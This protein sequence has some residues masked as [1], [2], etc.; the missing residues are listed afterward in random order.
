ML[1]EPGLSTEYIHHRELQQLT[2]EPA[3]KSS[4]FAFRFACDVHICKENKQVDW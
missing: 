1:I 3:L 4:M 2:R